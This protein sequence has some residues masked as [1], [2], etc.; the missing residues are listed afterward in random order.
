MKRSDGTF[1]REYPDS[2]MADKHLLVGSVL[3]AM[4]RATRIEETMILVAFLIVVNKRPDEIC[5]C[6]GCPVGLSP[7]APERS[8][9]GR[10]RVWQLERILF[11]LFKRPK[12]GHVMQPFLSIVHRGCARSLGMSNMAFPLGGWEPGIDTS[13]HELDETQEDIDFNVLPD[14]AAFRGLL[15]PAVGQGAKG[16]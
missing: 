10:K 8:F 4:W 2:G 3:V 5:F 6:F 11:V 14:D 9:V 15:R 1:F 12:R 13:V 7:E 16:G